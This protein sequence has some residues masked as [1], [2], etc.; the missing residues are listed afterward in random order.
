MRLKLDE[1]HVCRAVGNAADV[2]GEIQMALQSAA[3][4][5]NAAASEL[6]TGVLPED[7]AA[8]EERLIRTFLQDITAPI[9]TPDSVTDI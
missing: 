4:G 9:N 2:A 1:S 3:T 7:P 5:T 8:E 6:L